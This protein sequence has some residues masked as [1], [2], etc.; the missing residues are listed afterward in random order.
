LFCSLVVELNALFCPVY[1]PEEDKILLE[2]CDK[3][4][5]FQVL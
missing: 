3:P 5:L 2:Q 4:S 1:Y